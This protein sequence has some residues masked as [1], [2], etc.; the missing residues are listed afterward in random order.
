E[1]CS[2]TYRISVPRGP[3]EVTV[4]R[5]G[6]EAHIDRLDRRPLLDRIGGRGRLRLVTLAAASACLALSA[7]ILAAEALVSPQYQPKTA[8]TGPK[9]GGTGPAADPSGGDVADVAAGSDSPRRLGQFG[10]SLVGGHLRTAAWYRTQ[11]TRYQ[12]H[13]RSSH[14]M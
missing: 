8:D 5:N 13:Q 11:N 2:G 7:A 3:S 14:R 1:M 6:R 10:S 12:L 4:G 9:V